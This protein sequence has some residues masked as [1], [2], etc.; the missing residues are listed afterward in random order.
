MPRTHP[1]DEPRE[2]TASPKPTPPNP[3]HTTHRPPDHGAKPAAEKQKST[4]SDR[5]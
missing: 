3:Q 2:E 1:D 5:R 4:D